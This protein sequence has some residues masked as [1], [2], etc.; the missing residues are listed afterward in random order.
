MLGIYKLTAALALTLGVQ[1]FSIAQAQAAAHPLTSKSQAQ[2]SVSTDAAH[3]GVLGYQYSPDV[4]T[5]G[6]TQDAGSR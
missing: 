2:F 5:T 4:D 6:G 1:A 3:S